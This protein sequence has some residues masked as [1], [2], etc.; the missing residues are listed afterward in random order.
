LSVQSSR[1]ASAHSIHASLFTNYV[2]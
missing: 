2:S 1:H